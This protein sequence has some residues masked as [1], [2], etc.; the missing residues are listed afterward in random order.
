MITVN[1]AG[2]RAGPAWSETFESTNDDSWIL[3]I[4]LQMAKP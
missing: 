1:Q 3:L 2:M 4:K